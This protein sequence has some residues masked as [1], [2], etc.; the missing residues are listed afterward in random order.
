MFKK[1][2]FAILAGIILTAPGDSLG[3]RG[4]G[5]RA[6]FNR[7][8]TSEA[9]SVVVGIDDAQ[10]T[11]I[12]YPEKNW[13][14]ARAP[15]EVLKQIEEWIIKL[16][17]KETDGQ[18]YDTISVSYVDVDEVASRLNEV[19]T[20]INVEIQK[21]IVIQPLVESRQLLVFGKDEYRQM[22]KDLIKQIDLPSNQL[23]RQTFK[24]KYA[25]PE[26]IKTKL[27]EL[28]SM[29]GTSSGSIYSSRSFSRTSYG[30]TGASAISAN[31]V[32]ITTYPSL[33]QLV[34]LA[35]PDN[36]EKIKKQIEEWDSPIV[37]EELKPRIK[38][39]KNVDPV[40][41]V[42][43]LT[44]L[45]SS[46]G[47][48][49][50][51]VANTRQFLQASYGTLAT[52]AEKIIGPLYGKLT[53][54]DIPGT[55][56]I[57]IV[58][59]IAEAYDVVESFITEIDS[60]EMA[61]IPRVVQLKYADSEDLAQRLNTLVAEAGQTTS[62]SLSETGLVLQLRRLVVIPRHG[63]LVMVEAPLWMKRWKQATCSA[64]SASCRSQ[65]QNRF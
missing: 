62:I 18:A 21:N 7:S 6:G 52:D 16:D 45:F 11:L 14:I 8:R 2:T 65:I 61:V 12:P 55:K 42:D 24:I 41:M 20:E 17:I 26:D 32:I 57:I 56:K 49:S 31:T 40:Q 34:I 50:S 59:N 37:W 60:E 35:S 58:S 9:S 53:F 46:S 3:Q 64:G 39:V 5:E 4:G 27:D 36:M 54:A 13:I 28:Y 25:D 30:T 44:T 29:T 38:E 33:R 22:V 43:L 63:V 19:M 51:N 15:V 48:G 47:S 1:I 23:Q 10:I